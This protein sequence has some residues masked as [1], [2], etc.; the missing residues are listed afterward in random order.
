MNTDNPGTWVMHCHI[1]FHV[2]A[3][4]GMQFVENLDRIN[5]VSNSSLTYKNCDAWDLYTDF[6]VRA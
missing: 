4:L 3:G 1:A 2:G 6:N 5:Q